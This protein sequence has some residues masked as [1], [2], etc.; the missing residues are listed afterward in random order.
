MANR[1]E[2][3]RAVKVEI[4]RRSRPHQ[5]AAPYCEKCGLPAVT[6]QIDHRDPDAMQIDKSKP[7]TALEGWLLCLP[8]HAEKTKKDVG[9][10]AK[11][12]RREANHLGARKSR[13]SPKEPKSPLVT[14]QGKTNLSRRFQ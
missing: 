14:A 11:A 13:K 9:D 1:R 10:I 8:C 7:L 2:F 5:L 4:I 12:K 3:K 6:F